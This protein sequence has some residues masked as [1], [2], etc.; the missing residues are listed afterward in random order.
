VGVGA[1]IFQDVK[2]LLVRR[3]AKPGQG[4]WSIPGGLVE[5]GE[6]VHEAVVREVK[7][8]C[9]L[10]IEIERLVDVFDSITWDERGRIQYQFVVIN[11]LARI[12][13]G[14]L[15]NA[16]DV[17]DARWVSVDEVENYDLTNS[18]RRF[19]REHYREL[20]GFASASKG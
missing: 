20:K 2:L 6:R 9:G 15:K 12:K 3:G 1:L 18:F 11:F 14:R 19:F 8:E 16:D 7:E 4:R 17:L 5:L 13:G 10:D